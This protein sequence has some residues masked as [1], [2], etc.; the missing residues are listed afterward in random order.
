M[1]DRQLCILDVDDIL[2]TP[3]PLCT[4]VP[5]TCYARDPNIA[6][7]QNLFPR[8]DLLKRNATA[9]SNANVN[10][11]SNRKTNVKPK[12]TLTVIYRTLWKR[13]FKT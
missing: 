9:K 13:N 1:G 6:G 4:T 10:P 3:K 5:P 7:W 11:K 8:R 2:S 12:L